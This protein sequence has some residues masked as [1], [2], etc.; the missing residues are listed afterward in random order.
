MFRPPG[1]GAGGLVLN[2]WRAFLYRLT[3]FTTP[4]FGHEAPFDDTHMKPW[5]H[6]AFDFDLLAI[7]WG[8]DSRGK[9][10]RSGRD[11]PSGDDAIFPARGRALKH[12]SS[13]RLRTIQHSPIKRSKDPWIIMNLYL[14]DPFGRSSHAKTQLAKEWAALGRMRNAAASWSQNPKGH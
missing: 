5:S 2:I 7:P 12:N 13:L 11:R 9:G 6:E 1:K 14:M 4:V 8:K 3:A 10:G